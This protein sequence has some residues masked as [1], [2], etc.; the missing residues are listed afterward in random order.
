MRRFFAVDFGTDSNPCG[1][2]DPCPNLMG[3]W[4]LD[5]WR[6]DSYPFG[7]PDFIDPPACNWTR[8]NDY[9]YG[10][11][12]YNCATVTLNLLN[13]EVV[14]S[15]TIQYSGPA[16]DPAFPVDGWY[17]FSGISGSGVGRVIYYS[18]DFD[19]LSGGSFDLILNTVLQ[20]SFPTTYADFPATVNAVPASAGA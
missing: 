20:C 2:A 7:C 6:P 8:T 11:N 19:C 14:S 9:V 17:L 4:V 5:A 18:T 10:T 3:L 13:C 15:W 1:L 12:P 16:T